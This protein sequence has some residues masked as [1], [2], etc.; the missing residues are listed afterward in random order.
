MKAK[1][2]LSGLIEL[3][4]EAKETSPDE[5]VDSPA[6]DSAAPITALIR[7]APNE[8]TRESLAPRV[9]ID[10]DCLPRSFELTIVPG[11]EEIQ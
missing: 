6:Q 7:V 2:T 10:V 9:S 11:P 4:R 3:L 5:I 1:K 8:A